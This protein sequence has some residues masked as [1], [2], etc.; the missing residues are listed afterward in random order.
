MTRACLV[1]VALICGS[2]LV[3]AAP[4][5][6]AGLSAEDIVRKLILRAEAAETQVA[7]AEY[8]FIRK[9]ELEEFDGKGRL[10]ERRSSS[11]EMFF[12]GG[13]VTSS[14]DASGKVQGHERKKVA[15]PDKPHRGE[16]RNLLTDE[17]LGR[18]VF[19]LVGRTNLSGRSAYA[20]AFVPKQKNTGSDFAERLFNRVSGTIWVDV[21]EFEFALLQVQLDSEILVGAGL[22]GA[23]KNIDLMIERTRM[24]DGIWL[25]RSTKADFEARKFLGTT[26]VITTTEYSK[27][28]KQPKVDL[29]QQPELTRPARNQP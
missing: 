10:K 8:K 2:R 21:E 19:T 13:K 23:L 26:R 24:P 20:L 16:N 28:Q 7:D 12:R 14:A 25:E 5:G 15:N 18:Y 11:N 22:I 9:T 4:G 27:F 3:L 6:E 17:I 29:T 1:L